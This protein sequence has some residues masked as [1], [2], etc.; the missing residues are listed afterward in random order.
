MTPCCHCCSDHRH[1]WA[2]RRPATV[3]A[4]QQVCAV[5]RAG[6]RSGAGLG[7]RGRG[8]LAAA[9]ASHRYPEL[10]DRAR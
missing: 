2:G 5:R 8:L 7:H 1:A 6:H 3:G 4:G 9:C 10:N